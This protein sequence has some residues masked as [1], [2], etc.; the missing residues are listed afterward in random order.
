MMSWD[1][2]PAASG[3]MRARDAGE[4]QAAADGG[5]AAGCP[6]LALPEP[7][8]RRVIQLIDDRTHA[9]L[10]LSCRALRDTVDTARPT[11]LLVRVPALWPLRRRP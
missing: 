11:S 2:H 6:L 9:P 1:D 5:D 4:V 10:R 7:L 3:E 8:L